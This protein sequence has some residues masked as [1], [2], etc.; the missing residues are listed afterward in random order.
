MCNRLILAAMLAASAGPAWAANWVLVGKN[1][2][3]SVYEIDQ[4]S[5]VR[6]GPMVTLWLRVRYGPSNPPGESD[7]YT[8]RRRVNCDDH[9][10]QDLQTDYM[11]DGKVLRSSGEE[12][13]RPGKAGTIA[14]DVVI[15]ACASGRP[16]AATIRTNG[17]RAARR[18]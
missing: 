15:K 18:S 7:G 17:I 13:G 3:G 10:Y 5:V 12:E 16:V 1:S 6:E 2:S 14:D 8:A 4:Q 9:S 11:K